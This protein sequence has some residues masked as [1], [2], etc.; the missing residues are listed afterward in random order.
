MSTLMDAYYCIRYNNGIKMKIHCIDVDD[1]H[2]GHFW[3]SYFSINFLTQFPK[4]TVSVLTSERT[5][6]L[7]LTEA[8]QFK[9]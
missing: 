4:T 9:R 3:F 6:C 2:R 5:T 1:I 7:S 8:G